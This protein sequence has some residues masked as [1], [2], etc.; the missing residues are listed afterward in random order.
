[1]VVVGVRSSGTGFVGRS[2]HH[3]PSRSLERNPA[4]GGQHG[5]PMAH[6]TEGLSA[7]YGGS[8]LFLRLVERGTDGGQSEVASARGASCDAGRAEEPLAGATDSQ[9]AKTTEN[10]G[11]RG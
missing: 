3:G 6:L 1:M 8:E 11:P 5:L 4:P 9:S 7:V 2:P 10:G